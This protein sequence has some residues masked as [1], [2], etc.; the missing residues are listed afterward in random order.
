M[1]TCP[2]VDQNFNVI[3]VKIPREIFTES[4]KKMILRCKF[5]GQ[6]ERIG[7]RGYQP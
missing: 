4:K 2:P 3:P 7:K 5:N 1:P 6:K